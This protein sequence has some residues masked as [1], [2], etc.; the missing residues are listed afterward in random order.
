MVDLLPLSFTEVGKSVKIEK[1]KI[2]TTRFKIH[3]IDEV[4]DRPFMECLLTSF[5]FA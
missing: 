1:V 3:A 2:Y 5:Y 4:I